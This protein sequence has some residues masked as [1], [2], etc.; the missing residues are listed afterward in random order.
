MASTKACLLI[1][2]L[3]VVAVPSGRA[4]GLEAIKTDATCDV[5]AVKGFNSDEE[6][7]KLCIEA[8]DKMDQLFTTMESKDCSGTA[9]LIEQLFSFLPPN[10]VNFT[11]DDRTAVEAMVE[12][13][14]D[15]DKCFIDIHS[16][17]MWRD[18]VCSKLGDESEQRQAAARRFALDFLPYYHQDGSKHLYCF[19][20]ML[21]ILFNA[22][23]VLF[24]AAQCR[25]KS[26]SMHPLFTKFTEDTCDAECKQATK[27]ALVAATPDG[28]K[29]C[30]TLYYEKAFDFMYDNG[31]EVTLD[32]EAEKALSSECRDDNKPKFPCTKMAKALDMCL[33]KDFDE[34][35]TKKCHSAIH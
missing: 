24:P 21:S 22:D 32:E 15:K 4:A 19:P 27:D 14:M 17:W 10:G 20:T 6:R 25:S 9:Q 12:K 23:S 18:F 30:A 31:R 1:A 16:I 28:A 26:P 3:V 34:Y 35:K 8:C 29:C 33:G 11:V 5:E 2:F 13:I 7:E